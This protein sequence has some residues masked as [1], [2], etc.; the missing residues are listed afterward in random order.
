MNKEVVLYYETTKSFYD[1]KNL[2]EFKKCFNKNI[3]TNSRLK[4]IIEKKECYDFIQVG[5]F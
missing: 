1:F 2:D 4:K 3:E 5:L